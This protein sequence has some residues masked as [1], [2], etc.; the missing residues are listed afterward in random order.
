[1]RR[2]KDKFDALDGEF[3]ASVS[4]M[5]KEEID[6]RISD[7][8]KAD[9]QSKQAMKADDDLT[10]KKETVKL[11]ATPY[12]ET[13]KMARLRIAFGMQVLEERGTE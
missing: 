5:T 13:S 6:K 4:S 1:M 12:R 3:K 11:L 10:A 8:A 7:W 9:E 2:T